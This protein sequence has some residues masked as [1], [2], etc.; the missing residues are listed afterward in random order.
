M[1][2]SPGDPAPELG[3]PDQHGNIVSLAHLKDHHVALF[4]YP[5][6]DTP[7]CTQQA[8]G[9]R[10][11]AAELASLA[12]GAAVI[13]VS[14][15]TVGKQGKFDT[16]YDLGFTLLSDAE[17]AAAERYGVWVEKS[18]YGKTYMGVQR[19]AFLIDPDGNI[20]AAWYKISPK[21]TPT[22]FLEALA[23]P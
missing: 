12:P 21:D 15:D 1:T 6:A 2:L 16:K 10:D 9:M 14:P 22:A 13:G 5:K 19:S 17:H 4:F 3:L 23:K 11:I 8:Q 20:Q 7:G 18:M